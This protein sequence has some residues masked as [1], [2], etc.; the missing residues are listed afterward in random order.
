MVEG[1]LPAS[2]EPA[3]AAIFI[4]ASFFTSAL[5]ASMGIGGGVLMLA[6]MAYAMPVA[7]LIPVHGAVQF[8]SNA[9]RFLIQRRHV[10]WRPF[11]GFA[12]GAAFGAL[13]GAQFVV[14]L[15]EALLTLIL[16][17]FI[18][19]VTWLPL[20]RL[21]QIGGPGFALAG[22]VTTFVSMFVGATGPLNAAILGKAIYDRLTL[23]ATLAGVMASQHVFKVV[24]F[25]AT[26]FDFAEWL[27]LV[28]AMI[29]TGLAGTATGSLVLARMPETRFR[30]GMRLVLSLMALDLIRRALF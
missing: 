16:G 6:I 17:S 9:G 1:L 12:V 22:A 28:L 4:V 20:P 23:V 27:P 7:A 5:T 15:P 2:F 26:G 21:G 10:A 14:A 29:A 18:L 13:A 19:L 25:M 30:N 24:G 11:A 8:G 3:A